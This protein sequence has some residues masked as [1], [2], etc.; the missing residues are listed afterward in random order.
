MLKKINNLISR[1]RYK[2]KK[3]SVRIERPKV[4]HLSSIQQ[5][6]I[7]IVTDILLDPESELHTNPLDNKN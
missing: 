7:N 1:Y 4:E 2:F 5:K 3:I 6:V